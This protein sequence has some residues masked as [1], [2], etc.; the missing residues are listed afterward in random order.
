VR[1]SGILLLTTLAVALAILL[2][3]LAARVKV[4][5]GGLLRFSHP[6][7]PQTQSA[8]AAFQATARLT[9]SGLLDRTTR[10]ALDLGVD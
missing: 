5:R 7:S 10:E 6:D 2:A 3:P 4:P 8:V 9:A 1:P